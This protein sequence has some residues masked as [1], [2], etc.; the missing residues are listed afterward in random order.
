MHLLLCYRFILIKRH[1]IGSYVLW[2]PGK[3]ISQSYRWR[4]SLYWC[5]TITSGILIT[6]LTHPLS[7]I[8]C[9][10]WWDSI[11]ASFTSPYPPFHHDP[12]F[13]QLSPSQPSTLLYYISGWTINY[14]HPCHLSKQPLHSLRTSR[15]PR[16]PTL[17]YI[18][19]IYILTKFKVHCKTYHWSI[20]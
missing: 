13:S 19:Y 9:P 7:G 14:S 11:S 15:W 20:S 4:M 10:K 2:L 8:P 17:A 1:P 16:K 12:P 3:H 6:L 5:L 18:I